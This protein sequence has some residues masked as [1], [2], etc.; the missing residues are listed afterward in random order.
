MRAEQNNGDEDSVNHDRA[1]AWC[2]ESD[3]EGFEHAQQKAAEQASENIAQT[4]EDDHDEGDDGKGETHIGRDLLG[5][6][7][8]HAGEAREGEADAEAKQVNTR[9]RN[10]DQCGRLA[11]LDQCLDGEAQRRKAEEDNRADANGAGERRVR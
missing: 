1:I 8:Q 3:A 9:H 7:D 4:A 10:A 5:H 11:L 2:S 6:A